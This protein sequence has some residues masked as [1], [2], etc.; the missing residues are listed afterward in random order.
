MYFWV[1]MGNT[2]GSWVCQFQHRNYTQNI[3]T[4]I[5]V[6][7]PIVMVVGNQKHLCPWPSAFDVGRYET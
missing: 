1:K 5:V 7:W 6:K 2:I 3:L 4:Q